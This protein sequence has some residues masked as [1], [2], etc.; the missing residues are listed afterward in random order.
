[1]GQNLGFGRKSYKDSSRLYEVKIKKYEC[2]NQM[3][4]MIIKRLILEV[5]Y[6]FI[7]E[8]Q[9]AGKFLEEIE[10]FLPKMKSKGN[11][12]EYVTKMSNLTSKL[13]SLKLEFGKTFSYTWF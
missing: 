10:Q 8:S 5:F 11:I 6:G 4:L 3:Y 1:M 12:R 7:S 13:K 9:S 2:S